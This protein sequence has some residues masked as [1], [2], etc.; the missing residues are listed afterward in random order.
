VH[1]N[2]KVKLTFRD[3]I[4]NGEV[5]IYD[6][7]VDPETTIT[8]KALVDCFVKKASEF[9]WH[10]DQLPDWDQADMLL[11]RPERGMKKHTKENMEYQGDGPDFSK[12]HPV[13]APAGK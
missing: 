9:H 5:T 10:D 7:K 6:V 12:E 2:A 3:R 11:I 8:D 4:K 1:R 13:S